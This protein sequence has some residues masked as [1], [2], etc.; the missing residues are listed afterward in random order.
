LL[1]DFAVTTVPP[2][3]YAYNTSLFFPS[4]KNIITHDILNHQLGINATLLKTAS[5]HAFSNLRKKAAAAFS[6]NLN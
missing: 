6:K 1:F 4:S 5:K 3:L 2:V